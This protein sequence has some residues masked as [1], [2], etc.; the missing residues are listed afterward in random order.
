M[1]GQE[2]AE[3]GQSP[4]LHCKPDPFDTSA[5]SICCPQLGRTWKPKGPNVAMLL[6]LARGP[7]P[8]RAARGRWPAHAASGLCGFT[9]SSPSTNPPQRRED[10]RR[11]RGEEVLHRRKETQSTH[12]SG[13]GGGAAW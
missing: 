13:C 3:R 5:T 4:T 9:R 12:R 11:E 7:G 2:A 1:I 10:T 8:N 6:L